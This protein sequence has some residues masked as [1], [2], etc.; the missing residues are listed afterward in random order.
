MRRITA[1]A[2]ATPASAAERH[3]RRNRQRRATG[4]P[5]VA[6]VPV[7]A[8]IH[9]TAAAATT[10]TADPVATVT[11]AWTDSG[12]IS[13]RRP[14]QY[15]ESRQR[16]LRTRR[17][18]RADPVE[19]Q[20]TSGRRVYCPLVRLTP[21]RKASRTIPRNLAQAKRPP[22]LGRKERMKDLTGLQDR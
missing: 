1:V 21:E 16:R 6:P 14:L 20:I 13:G 22:R 11:T 15:Q 9:A 18:S 7:T 10:T 19:L 17:E 4:A 2:A 5:A 12:G 8:G 3:Q